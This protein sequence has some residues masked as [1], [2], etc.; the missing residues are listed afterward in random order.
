MTALRRTVAITC[1]V[2]GVVALFAGLSARWLD[3]ELFDTDRFAATT[4][5]IL[6]FGSVQTALEERLTSQIEP[7]VVPDARPL[8]APVVAQ[9]VADARFTTILDQAVRSAHSTLV[10][11]RDAPI[12][13]DLTPAL[14]IIR[15][16]LTAV[17]PV[18]GASVGELGD[19]MR[20][21]IA[22]RG[23]VPGGW[24]VA[25]RVHGA[26]VAMLVFG[27]LLVA[28]GVVV[29]PERW[30]IALIGGVGVTIGAVVIYLGAGMIAGAIDSSIRDR[31]NRRA[32]RDITAL[33]VDPLRS[34]M[35]TVMIAGAIASLLGVA[36]WLLRPRPAAVSDGATLTRR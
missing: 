1:C 7:R 21:V 30:L 10:G 27:G 24:R 26:W 15:T 33:F 13:L 31:R 19:E 8:V 6:H 32:A 12:V 14:A 9:V 35:T 17:D 5:Q 28:L 34:E 2:A 20:I 16:E 18:A 36:G 25:D 22:G 29:A 23:D 11:G 4:S 3:R